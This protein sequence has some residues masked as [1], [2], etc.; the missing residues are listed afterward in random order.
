MANAQ[1]QK[2]IAKVIATAELR[3]SKKVTIHQAEVRKYKAVIQGKPVEYDKMYLIFAVTDDD[4]N[5]F[6]GGMQKVLMLGSKDD[7]AYSQLLKAK[8]GDRGTLTFSVSEQI[9]DETTNE[10]GTKSVGSHV[11]SLTVEDFTPDKKGDN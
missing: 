8:P 10:D 5:S 11:V 4:N 2:A 7:P 9:T 1:A 3:F 6:L